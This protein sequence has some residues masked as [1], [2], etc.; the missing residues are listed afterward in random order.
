MCYYRDGQGCGYYRDDRDKKVPSM[1][2]HETSQVLVGV[3]GRWIGTLGIN[4]RVAWYAVLVVLYS[5]GLRC[6]VLEVK[7]I[8]TGGGVKGLGYHSLSLRWYHQC[9]H[10]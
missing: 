7:S 2:W 4:E 5:L 1:R 10:L 6:H 9:Q 8:D 3:I